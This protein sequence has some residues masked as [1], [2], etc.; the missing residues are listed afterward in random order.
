MVSGPVPYRGYWIK[1]NPKPIPPRYGVD[2]DWWH[3]GYDGPGDPRCGA[4]GSLEA[5]R[6]AIDEQI[7][8]E[9]AP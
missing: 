7:E 8:D 9:E 4:T 2:W 6:L 5:A 1:Y 3:D